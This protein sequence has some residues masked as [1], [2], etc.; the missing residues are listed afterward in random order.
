VNVYGPDVSHYQGTVDWHKVAASGEGFAFVKASQGMSADPMFARNRA[1]SLLL[2]VRGCYHFG[3]FSGDAAAQAQFFVRTVGKIHD[4]DF[5]VLDAE[6]TGAPKGQACVDW[7][8]TFLATV[9]RES[10]LPASRVLVYT[11]AW[12]W[13]P[14]TLGSSRFVD[15]PLWVSGYGKKP[16]MPLG[17]SSALLWQYTNSARVPGIPGGNDRSVY[18]GTL[19]QLRARAG[20]PVVVVP[21]GGGGGTGVPVPPLPVVHLSDIVRGKSSVSA[22]LV[23]QALVASKVMPRALL[24]SRWSIASQLYFGRYRKAHGTDTPGALKALGRSYGFTVAP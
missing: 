14:H 12:W 10:G 4:G 21:G 18:A 20:N 11:G 9:Q 7:I 24:R 22:Y 6:D 5:L 16:S 23:N 8:A 15:H 17:Y 13:N 3:N 1:G 19:A 2:S